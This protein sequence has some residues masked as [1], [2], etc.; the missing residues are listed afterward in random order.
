MAEG[1]RNSE[2]MEEQRGMRFGGLGRD[3]ERERR[4]RISGREGWIEI[5]SFAISDVYS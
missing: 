3:W 4:V 5:C 2:E 1:V